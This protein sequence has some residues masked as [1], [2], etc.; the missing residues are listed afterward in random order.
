MK[1]VL[2]V[3]LTVLCCVSVFAAASDRISGKAGV[4]I[5]FGNKGV[6]NVDLDSEITINLQFHG[7]SA[8]LSLTP[9][10]EDSFS[11]KV[12]QLSFTFTKLGFQENL[13]VTFGLL[14][15][16]FSE[17]TVLGL[18][19]SNKIENLGEFN[20]MVNLDP[21][22]FSLSKDKFSWDSLNVLA[23]L[24]TDY[25]TIVE[26]VKV[27]NC[28]GLDYN[29]TD[30]LYG[31]DKVQLTNGT[32]LFGAQAIVKRNSA[33]VLLAS[34]YKTK[35]QYGTPAAVLGVDFNWEDNFNARISDAYVSVSE[36]KQIEGPK[37]TFTFAAGYLNCDKPKAFI[38]GTEIGTVNTKDSEMPVNKGWFAT[39]NVNYKLPKK[40]ALNFNFSF[41]MDSNKQI[42]C[43]S[44]LNTQFDL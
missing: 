24:D 28:F 20:A 11:V 1:K 41:G 14:K 33:S 39:T 4:K 17:E 31:F 7:G 27:K 42:L 35:T 34:Q 5:E 10:F 36:V 21:K 37:G 19:C 12:D 40:Q 32:M 30:S 3:L 43:N 9:D 13:K 38:F 2:L 26:D 8:L 44:G 18:R 16:E 15:D 22:D 29:H 6:S 23:W 25:Y